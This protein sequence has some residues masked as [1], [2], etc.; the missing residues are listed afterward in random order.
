ML[1]L[2]G[3][4][5]TRASDDGHTAIDLAEANGHGAL[6]KVLRMAAAKR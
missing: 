6:A 3:A 1:Q 5:P 2:R 4:D